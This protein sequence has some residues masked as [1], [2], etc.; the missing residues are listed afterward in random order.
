M[1]NRMI[2]VKLISGNEMTFKPLD[3]Q[4]IFIQERITPEERKALSIFKKNIGTFITP[5]NKTSAYTVSLKT[6]KERLETQ[7]AEGDGIALNEAAVELFSSWCSWQYGLGNKEYKELFKFNRGE[8][9]NAGLMESFIENYNHLMTTSNTVIVNLG[10]IRS[11][12]VKYAGSEAFDMLTSVSEYIAAKLKHPY[13]E[14][15]ENTP[16]IT[17]DEE[18][19]TYIFCEY[20]GDMSKPWCKCLLADG[21]DGELEYHILERSKFKPIT[22]AVLKD[23][24]A[25]GQTLFARRFPFLR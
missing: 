18:A 23:S 1:E 19:R 12:I 3:D 6:L 13:P 17:L 5:E 15:K 24:N 7:L 20:Q 25:L 8:F 2:K 4:G 10:E 16:V 11:H 22:E 9:F 21:Y 14:I